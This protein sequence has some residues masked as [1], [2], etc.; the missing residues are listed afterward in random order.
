V[1][2]GA[3]AFFDAD[4]FIGGSCVACGR[5]HFPVADWCPWC[6]AD[7]TVEV[8]L[9]TAGTLW[10]WTA[11]NAPPPG[12][13]GDTPYGFGVV[14]LAQDGLRIISRLTESDP[15]RLTLG[16]AMAFTT[17]DVGDGSTTWAFDPR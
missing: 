16:Q 7:G 17:V 8:R 5:R 10:A 6:G 14:E 1:S 11:V 3:P 13:E 12:Y 2:S 4:G 9:S 15:S